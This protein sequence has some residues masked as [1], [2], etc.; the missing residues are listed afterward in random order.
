MEKKN[1]KSKW[2]VIRRVILGVTLAVIAFLVFFAVDVFD[3]DEWHDFE[4]ELILDSKKSLM[5][6]DKNGGEASLL[7]SKENRQWIG[8]D[9]IPMH[10]RYAFISAE[11]A[12]FYE[13]GGVD[14]IRIFGAALHDLKVGSLEQGG[15]NDKPAAY[16]TKPS[17]YRRGKA[18]KNSGKKA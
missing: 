11:D 2:R 18:G 16:K 1:K 4:P 7:Y 13:H 17:D 9:E 14:I 8:I 3:M 15:V 5:V 12:R 6:Y 10:A